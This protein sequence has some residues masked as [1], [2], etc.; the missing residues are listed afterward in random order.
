M[1][2]TDTLEKT[3]KP[4]V[5]EKITFVKACGFLKFLPMLVITSYRHW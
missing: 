1:I 5:N 2:S 3:P 4:S